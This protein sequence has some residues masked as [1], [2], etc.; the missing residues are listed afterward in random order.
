MLKK[1][2][3]LAAGKGTRLEPLTETRPKCLIQ[4]MG[5]SFLY[6]ILD[7]LKKAGYSDIAIIVGY[8]KEMIKQFC[9]EYKFK[10][11]FIE[12]KEQ[13]GTGDAI[14]T[15]R[16]FV[17]QDNFVVIMSD[18][19]YSADDLEAVRKDDEFN[20]VVGFEH[21]HPEKFG[22]LVEGERGFLKRI[23]EKPKEHVGNLIN[24]GLYKLTPEI[25][26]E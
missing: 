24:T 15:A 8:K 16:E 7:N 1:A 12:Q 2:V 10:V 26:S 17:G 20:Y 25:F 18:N 6:Y 22:V 11:T 13:K 14:K 3:I 5:K 21:E 4:V 23:V 9:E 19:L